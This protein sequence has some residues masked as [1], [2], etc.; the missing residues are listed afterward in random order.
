MPAAP[1]RSLRL[2]ASDDILD[3]LGRHAWRSSCKTGTTGKIGD[4]HNLCQVKFSDLGLVPVSP[5]QRQWRR[6]GGRAYENL[7]AFSK[8][9]KRL[10]NSE[11]NG[12]RLTQ[13]MGP[14]LATDCLCGLGKT[15][16]LL[17]TRSLQGAMATMWDPP[18]QGGSDEF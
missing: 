6:N 18:K 9:P 12:Q 15:A 10:A 14:G 1:C 3:S 13:S 16:L 4:L 2:I 7:S 5:G 11:P 8:G 17:Q